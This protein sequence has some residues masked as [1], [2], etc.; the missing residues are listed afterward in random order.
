M[1]DMPDVTDSA[2]KNGRL[3]AIPQYGYGT[4]TMPEMMW[5][6]KDWREAAGIQAP[7]TITEL[8]FLMQTFMRAH[9]GT[10]GMPLRDGLDE[11]NWLAPAF[12]AYP[13]YW[14]TGAGDSIMFG[15]IQPEMKPVLQTFADWY[16][17]GYLKQD[18]MSSNYDSNRSD[19]MTEKFGFQIF[20]Q[21][22]GFVMATDMMSNYGMNAYFEAFD[23]P[24]AT[25]EPVMHPKD[26]D[27]GGYL[28]VNKNCKNI[29]AALKCIS[30]AA[31]GNEYLANQGLRTREQTNALFYDNGM[32]H[33]M[34]MIET[35]NAVAQREVYLQVLQTKKTGIR[36]PELTD[37]CYDNEIKPFL[38]NGDL[39]G[40]GRW[41][42]MWADNSAYEVTDR[43]GTENR[44]VVS[45]MQGPVPEEIAAYGSTLNDILTEGFIQIIVGQ[46]P[47]SYFDT[48]VAQWKAAGGDNCT[49]VMNQVYGNK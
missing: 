17:K 41:L 29:A 3:Y 22:W 18:W 43:I 33:F 25:G 16:K 12:G 39:R 46:Q 19:L 5:I 42:Q 8:E 28:V 13:G 49:Q 2:K 7:K 23:L 36:P 35:M 30:W 10:Y 45:R 31:A 34:P 21:W 9:P 44:W 11:F 32:W 26:F 47:V 37:Q 4:L 27:N 1:A 48:L 15:S 14:I 38:E 6:R 24:S 20:P 40:A